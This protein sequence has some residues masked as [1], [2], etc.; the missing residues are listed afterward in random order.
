D[1][2]GRETS[3][4]PLHRTELGATD[5]R[6]NS[7]LRLGAP[8]Y[9][10]APALGRFATA[11]LRRIPDSRNLPWSCVWSAFYRDGRGQRDGGGRPDGDPR[12]FLNCFR[13]I[14]VAHSPAA[15]DRKS[16]TAGGRALDDSDVDSQPVAAALRRAR[17]APLSSGAGRQIE[18]SSG[19]GEHWAEC[20][21]AR[22]YRCGALQD[23]G[24]N[25]T[26]GLPGD[27]GV[28]GC[29]HGRRLASWTDRQRESQGDDLY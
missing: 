19:R 9:D 4:P 15:D 1:R 21:R 22:T 26:S 14:A 16:H 6:G 8:G 25:S 29:Q 18:T 13:A 10:R 3:R 11:D 23:A 5:A 17:P 24:G 2:D 28:G 12:R 20:V 27:A 7:K